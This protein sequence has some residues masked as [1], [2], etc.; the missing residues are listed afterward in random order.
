[1]L[2]KGLELHVGID[3]E[4]AIMHQVAMSAWPKRPSPS[5]KIAMPLT[6][7]PS[8]IVLEFGSIFLVPLMKICD[9]AA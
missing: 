8:S 4:S 9:V 2:V 1:M 3:L 5:A 7:N 6:K